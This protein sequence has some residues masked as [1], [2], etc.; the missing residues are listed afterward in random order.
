MLTE[1]KIRAFSNLVADN[2]Y[3]ALG[4]VLIGALASVKRVIRPLGKERVDLED[5]S[6]GLNEQ[7]TLEDIEV[8]A[9][10]G[11]V[12]K[13]E[14]IEMLVETRFEGQRNEEEDDE[15]LKIK[16]GKKKRK[17]GGGKDDKISEEVSKEANSTKRPK[18]KRKKGDAFDDLFSSLI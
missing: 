14:E 17:V 16:K 9:D 10:F 3:A 8:V 6:N 7:K 5:S 12:V 1:T 11:E 2:Q 15:R 18:K 13:R 4:L